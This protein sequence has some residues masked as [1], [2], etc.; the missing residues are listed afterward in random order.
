[1]K[2]IFDVN[3]IKERK[4]SQKEIE[5]NEKNRKIS[6]MLLLYIPIIILIII[7]AIYIFVIRLD[8]LLIPF[9]IVFLIF[10]FGWDANQRTCNNC[11]KWN[12]VVW[13]DNKL[14]IN[15]TK[16]EKKNFL[17]I[18]KTKRE[19][20]DKTVGKCA[21]CGKEYTKEKIKKL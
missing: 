17:G 14:I 16:E 1:M 11:K 18:Q 21:N 8:V 3:K 15:E 10:L 9:A 2:K 20:I 6:K 4:V 19:R 5:Q 12:S 13:V 7:S